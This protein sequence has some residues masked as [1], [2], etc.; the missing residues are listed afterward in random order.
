[1]ERTIGQKASFQSV[2]EEQMITASDKRRTIFGYFIKASSDHE[3][4]EKLSHLWNQLHEINQF[5]EDWPADTDE[6]VQ[7]LIDNPVEMLYDPEDDECEDAFELE[8]L[9][10]ACVPPDFN[11][12]NYGCKLQYIEFDRR[13]I[14]YAL[15]N[16]DIQS[17]NDFLFDITQDFGVKKPYFQRSYTICYNETLMNVYWRR[18]EIN[19]PERSVIKISNKQAGLQIE[20]E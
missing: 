2:F 13:L 15:R 8:R 11:Y 3:L 4:H 10:T 6:V 7:H 16:G 12:H 5:Q 9:I 1:M 18:I 19:Y 17:E 20:V 14:Q